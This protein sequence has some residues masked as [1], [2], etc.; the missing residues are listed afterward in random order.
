M[1]LC[2]ELK[3][4]EREIRDLALEL[5]SRDEGVGLRVLGEALLVK[6]LKPVDLK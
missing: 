5:V 4:V 1:K 6:G 3:R 2:E